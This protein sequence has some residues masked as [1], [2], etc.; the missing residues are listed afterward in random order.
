MMNVDEDGNTEEVSFSCVKTEEVANRSSSF[1]FIDNNA[2]I[3]V[4]TEGTEIDDAAENY[5]QKYSDSDIS[6][7]S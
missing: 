3:Q 1:S 7:S 5:N 4:K 2:I 6:I